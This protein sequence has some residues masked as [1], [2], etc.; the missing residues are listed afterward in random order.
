METSR[1]TA[2]KKINSKNIRL[3][4]SKCLLQKH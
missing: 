4:T 1:A 3:M 2:L